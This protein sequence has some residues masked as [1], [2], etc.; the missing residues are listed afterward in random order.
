ME[1]LLYLVHRIPY[2][3]NKGDKI[4]SFNWLKGLSKH[5]EIHLGTFVDDPED[6]QFVSELNQYC[7]S[8]H[9]ARLNPSIA[10][11]KS[12]RGLLANQA[13]SVPYYYDSALQVWVDRLLGEHGIDK[14][15][16][17]SSSMA[18]YVD[19]GKYSELTRVIDFV[20]VDSDKWRQYA[21][22]KSWPASYIYAREAKKLLDYEKGIARS[23]NASVF[24]SD[25]EALSFKSMLGS[26]DTKVTY[27]NNGVDADYFSPSLNLDNPY[28]TGQKSIVFTGA[29]DYW[30]N[31]DAVC[32]FVKEVF[33]LLREKM[34][35]AQFYIVGSKPTSEVSVLSAVDGV[36][37]TGRVEDVR[38][39]IK[40]ATVSVAPMRIARGIQNKVLEA[41]AMARPVVA[42][43]QGFEGI[44][45]EVDKEIRI[46]EKP[47]EY[48]KVI[49]DIIGA[50]DNDMGEAA[51]QRVIEDYTWQ[52]NVEKLVK[53]LNS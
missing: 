25:A 21:E 24:V 50:S 16:V 7:K 45:A 42:S 15:L 17:F 31:V 33:P 19:K 44:C 37:V 2:P 40:Y 22:N 51:R 13:L 1:K 29:M 3:P 47:L 8:V 35:N 5:Y 46:A 27:S 11:L 18:Q 52:S 26:D 43:P 34:A 6:E 39:Y 9:I 12:L 14:V 53:L 49:K 28:P 30:A 48:V 32:W 38:P 36:T 10:R 23:F 20:D 4:R 41:M